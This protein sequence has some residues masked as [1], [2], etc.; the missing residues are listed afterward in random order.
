MVSPDSLGGALLVTNPSGGTLHCKRVDHLGQA[1]AGW[2][3]SDGVDV[4]SPPDP[5]NFFWATP[6]GLGG[7]FIEWES[8]GTCQR[9]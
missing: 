1:V 3:G 5:S 7:G 6:D 8:S 9:L 4:A 2:G